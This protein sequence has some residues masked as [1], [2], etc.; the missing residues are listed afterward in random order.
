MEEHT[1]GHGMKTSNRHRAI[2]QLSHELHTSMIWKNDGGRAA[3]LHP[4][5]NL[6]LNMEEHNYKQ[7]WQPGTRIAVSVTGFL[8]LLW[9]TDGS[10]PRC[11][12]RNLFHMSEFG[13]QN[14]ISPQVSL[15][16]GGRDKRFAEPYLAPSQFYSGSPQGGAAP[17]VAL[18][19]TVDET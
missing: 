19:A 2:P 18:W 10:V 15:H 5:V 12:V 9:Q 16:S 11:T 17:W 8:H 7:G 1:T 6:R 13:R 3:E 14:Q 4:S